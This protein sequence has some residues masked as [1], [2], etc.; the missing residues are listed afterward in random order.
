MP[1]LDPGFFWDIVEESDPATLRSLAEYSDTELVLFFRF[2][3]KARQRGIDS[4]AVDPDAPHRGLSDQAVMR[5]VPVL[6]MDFDGTI[7]RGEEELPIEPE[8]GSEAAA[9]VSTAL[10]PAKP[11]DSDEAGHAFQIEAGH[12]FRFEAGQCSDLKSATWRHSGGSRRC[13]SCF[14][15][16]VKRAER[17]ERVTVARREA[18]P[19]VNR[20]D[21]AR[22][23]A[24]P[25]S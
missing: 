8:P 18:V 5:K 25:C 15:I 9:G 21:P 20:R 6:N 22:D 23:A 14:S 11:A 4:G 10:E 24:C 7:S 12:P 13:C 19:V 16:W 2:F 3:R 1:R 17:K